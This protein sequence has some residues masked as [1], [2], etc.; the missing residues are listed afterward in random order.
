M[1]S[2]FDNDGNQIAQLKRVK[3]KPGDTCAHSMKFPLPNFK[4]GEYYVTIRVLDDMSGQVCETSKDFIV[5]E[6]PV[7]ISEVNLD[8][9]LY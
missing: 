5:L 8:K 4:S 7:A 2:F 1:I 3:E 9:W 6:Q